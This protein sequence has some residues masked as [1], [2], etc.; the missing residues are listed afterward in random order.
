MWVAE[1]HRLILELL[2]AHQGLTTEK[3]ADALGVSRETVRRDLIELE[4]AGHLARVHGGA[5][6]AAVEQPEPA[7]AERT[8]LRREEKREIAALAA[9]LPQPGDAC[10]LDA[11]STTLALAEALAQRQGLT[12]ITNSVEAARVLASRGG[13][14]VRLLGGR[15]DQDVPATYGDE[16]IAEVS[17][18]HVEWAFVSPVS[19]SA[20]GGAMDYV[21]HEAAMARAMLSRAARR[22]LLADASKLG[23]T[24]RIQ[25]C[26]A[27]DV[28]VLVTDSGASAAQLAAFRQ[29]GVPTILP[30]SGDATPH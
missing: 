17:R 15:L 6:A 5:V 19:F 24:S 3:F 14:D 7:Y 26:P 23:Q 10:L 21:W 22:V 1:R 30:A 9:A 25:V 8:R 16:T 27:S 12:V 18:F 11:G 20:D 4:K 28:D 2:G 29:A 13:H